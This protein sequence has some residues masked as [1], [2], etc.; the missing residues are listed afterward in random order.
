M[1][2]PH[3]SVTIRQRY[4]AI[5]GPQG[6]AQWNDSFGRALDRDT[7]LRPAGMHRGHPFRFRIEG[8]L[9]NFGP[10]VQNNVAPYAALVR[11]DEQRKLCRITDTDKITARLRP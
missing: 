2:Q 5:F 1:I 4:F 8:D 3:L 6:G 7:D 9:M 11:G 10:S